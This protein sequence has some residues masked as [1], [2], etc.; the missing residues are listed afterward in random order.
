MTL[1]EANMDFVQQGLFARPSSEGMGKG[2]ATP[3]T[4]D[5]THLTPDMLKGEMSYDS[6]YVEIWFN[7]PLVTPISAQAPIPYKIY[8]FF[9]RGANIIDYIDMLF[10]HR[11]HRGEYEHAVSYSDRLSPHHR[12]IILPNWLKLMAKK[13]W[14]E[15]R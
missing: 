9:D 12:N 2:R 11:D 7:C 13:V 3:D 1:F 4:F 5:M 10:P 8:M 6:P 14:R 15:N